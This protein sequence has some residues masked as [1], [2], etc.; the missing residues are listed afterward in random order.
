MCKCNA[1][2][3]TESGI[4]DSLPM[5]F[6]SF[7]VI[8]S[9]KMAKFNLAEDRYDENLNFFVFCSIC[10]CTISNSTNINMA[11]LISMLFLPSESSLVPIRPN[12][13]W[14]PMVNMK[15]SVSF[16]QF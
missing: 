7:G 8:L 6:L 13:I 16:F 1:S 4:A 15:I 3:S 11:N 12:P 14:P 5:L 9:A 2:N 10:R